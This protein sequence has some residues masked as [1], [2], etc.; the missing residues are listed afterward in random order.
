MDATVI[1]PII[2]LT[3][4]EKQ[5]GKTTCLWVLEQ[6]VAHPLSTA[7]L[8]AA[9]LFR[10]VDKHRP[11]LLIDEAD[12]F[13][14]DDDELVGLVNSSHQRG[15]FSLRCVGDDFEV[16]KFGT[17][18]ASVFAAIGKLPNTIEDRSIVVQMVRKAPDETVERFRLDRRGEL[19]PHRRQAW[20]WAQDHLDEL[21]QAEPEMPTR[22]SDRG[23]DNWKPLLGIADM[24]GG[25]W[26]ERA[27]KAAVT[28]AALAAET[29]NSIPIQLLADIW[30]MFCDVP[31]RDGL[32]SAEIVSRLIAQEDRPW[33]ELDG[34][35][36]TAHKL[37]AMLKPFDIYPKKRRFGDDKSLNGYGRS[38]F[39]EPVRRY[40]S[41]FHSGLEQESGL[42]HSESPESPQEINVVPL[43]PLKTA[44]EAYGGGHATR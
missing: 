3:S 11:T 21:R 25:V 36:I 32:P 34:K 24:A 12:R 8:S 1:T 28:L 38:D 20:T 22:L 18:T 17:F 30:T 16:R 15:G 23:K 13:L 29:E 7:N 19:E 27:R 4:A 40:L 2:T 33:A 10:V 37:A 5:S 6:L 43:V 9:V 41:L 44:P 31:A 14:A 39:E 42:F 26:P 35:A